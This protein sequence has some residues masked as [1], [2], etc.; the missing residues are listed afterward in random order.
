MRLVVAGA[1][2]TDAVVERLD[3][4][5]NT[6]CGRSWLRT[7]D[8]INRHVQRTMPNTDIALR[9]MGELAGI[10]NALSTLIAPP[11]ADDPAN[12]TPLIEL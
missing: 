10:R 12:D 5:Q 9:W 3:D 8:E 4:M 11:D 2:I 6:E 7:L 1:N